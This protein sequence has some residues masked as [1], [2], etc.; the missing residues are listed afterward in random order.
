MGNGKKMPDMEVLYGGYVDYRNKENVANRYGDDVKHYFHA[1][2]S[3]M[4]IR[5][6]WFSTNDAPVTDPAEDRGVRI[7]RLGTVVHNDYEQAM[8]L[9]NKRKRKEAKEKENN[10]NN[11]YLELLDTIKHIRTEGEVIIPELNVQGFYDAVVEMESGEVYLYDF[12]T[13]GSYPWKTTFG[14]NPNDNK[15]HHKLQLA[16]YGIAIQLEYG[17]LDGMFLYYYNK[18]TSACK[19]VPVP[20]SMLGE[21]M[22]YWKDVNE[23][24]T[25]SI[26]PE[27]QSGVSPKYAWECNYCQF[28]THCNEWDTIV[29]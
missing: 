24:G 2:S 9:F 13:I 19:E 16:T 18:D 3:G 5:K 21:A 8:A 6:N 29:G 22:A 4:C 25:G 12:K 23:F 10:I 17:R 11:N 15:I 26:P 7:M 1:S 28:S 14:R 27:I 20:M